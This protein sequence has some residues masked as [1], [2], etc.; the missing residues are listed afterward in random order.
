MDA[1]LKREAGPEARLWEMLGEE[2][3]KPIGIAHLPMRHSLEPDGGAGVAL[4]ADGLYPTIDDIAKLARLLHAGGRH[5]GRQLLDGATLARITDFTRR[6]GLATKRADWRYLRS[7]WLWRFRAPDGACERQIPVLSG[8]GGQLVM[9]LP[10]GMTAF[11]FA[12]DQ[13]HP[14]RAMARVADRL[15]PFCP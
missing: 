8:T 4:L 5:Q 13:A 14:V 12:D 6:Q 11:R 9:L 10:N 2:V 1:F 3:L 7:F 15:R